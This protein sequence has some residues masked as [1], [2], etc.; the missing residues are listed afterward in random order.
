MDNDW[1]KRE[2]APKV[3]NLAK[4]KPVVSIVGPRQSGKTT[5]CKMLFPKK[6]MVSL[7]DIDEREF[8]REDPRG[9]LNRFPD[10]VVIDEVQRVPGLLSYIQ[11]LV[12]NR[13][14]KGLFILTGSDQLNLSGEISQSLA[15]RTGIVKLLP[16]SLDEAYGDKLQTQTIESVLY[17]GFYPRIFKDNLNPSQE[18]ND[19]IETY[20]NKDVRRLVNIK[21]QNNFDRFLKICAGRT[22]Q[23]LNIDS[24]GSDCGLDNQTVK[25][26]LAILEASYAIKLIA[27]FHN[28]YDKRLIKS[29]KLYFLDTGLACRLI[30]ITDP[31]QLITHPLKGEIFETFVISEILKKQFNSTGVP[32]DLYFFRDNKFEVDLLFQKN[33]KLVQIEI[34]SGQ[35]IGSDFFK[36]L[37][38]LRNI[39][40][41]KPG[42]EIE[43]SILIYGGDDNYTRND[44]K[45]MSWKN[46]PG[47]EVKKTLS[48]ELVEQEDP[49]E[50]HRP[51]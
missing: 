43:E 3:L 47:L 36:N 1:I 51:K 13:N 28:N 42:P 12:D 7:E 49:E 9:F 32:E 19:Y 8:A 40:F 37:L 23:L 4:E 5:L 11:T 33:A 20:I 14:E 21:K 15:G 38:H 44:I 18:M 17:T 22:G 16:F 26:W 35:T 29:P 30:G 39:S 25:E 24:L 2:I 45:V 34:K 10:G 48:A 6:A 27:P 41:K 50:D 46:L 31:S